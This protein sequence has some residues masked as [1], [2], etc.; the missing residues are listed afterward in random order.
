MKT[1]TRERKKLS[2]KNVSLLI[3]KKLNVLS[4]NGQKSE[5]SPSS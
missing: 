2:V 5:I 3:L 4:S 1:K